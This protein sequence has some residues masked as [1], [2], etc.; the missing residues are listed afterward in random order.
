MSQ[1]HL[2][3]YDNSW[4]HPGRS[5]SWQIAWFLLGAP[6]V[7]CSI[8]PSSS[9]RVRLLR[10]FG[11]QVGSRV[12]IKPDVR[13]KY[14]WHLSV[15]SDVWIGESCWIDNLT[16]VRIGN[17]VCISQGAYLC[18][19]NHN[20]SDPAFA[21]QTGTIELGDGAW[22]GARAFLSPGVVVAEGGVAAAGSV[23]TKNIGAYEIHAGNPASFV[24]RRHFLSKGQPDLPPLEKH[25]TA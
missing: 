18:T 1:V 10:A 22:V 14:P 15:G 4:Y 21:L 2:R 16:T 8:C 9:F 6:V 7:R 19:G 3:A 25:A 5:K 17:D 20:W 11:A 13:I 24:R 23:I 12:V